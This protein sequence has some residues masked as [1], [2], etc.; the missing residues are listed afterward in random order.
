VAVL[1]HTRGP[2]VDGTPYANPAFIAQLNDF[3]LSAARA[4]RD[5]STEQLRLPVPAN[6]EPW[7]VALVADP[8]VQGLNGHNPANPGES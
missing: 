8:E 2:V 7:T 4:H 6:V 3:H 1:E 5:H